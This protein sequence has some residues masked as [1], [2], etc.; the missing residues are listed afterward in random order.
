MLFRARLCVFVPRDIVPVG[1]GAS[2]CAFVGALSKVLEVGAQSIRYLDYP[3]HIR[4]SEV[5]ET[6]FTDLINLFLLGTIS[7]MS[8]VMIQERS[9]TLYWFSIVVIS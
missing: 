5:G 3:C 6:A 8:A 7:L 4:E 1:I 2:V 9:T